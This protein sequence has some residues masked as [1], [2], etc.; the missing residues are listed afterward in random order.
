MDSSI[1]PKFRNN[2]LCYR[3]AQTVATTEG[4]SI[5]PPSLPGS[6]IPCT[7]VWAVSL[8][9][10]PCNV[11]AVRRPIYL[12]KMWT[13]TS[14]WKQEVKHYNQAYSSMSLCSKL[15]L[16]YML[17]TMLTTILVLLFLYF[18]STWMQAWTTS[19]FPLLGHATAPHTVTARWAFTGYGRHV[20]IGGS[21]N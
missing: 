6:C 12:H 2:Y 8:Y 18:F 17:S 10:W 9:T 20:A 4:I 19:P 21:W 13:L 15:S 3:V 14:A 5:P 1:S 11:F 16:K 7:A